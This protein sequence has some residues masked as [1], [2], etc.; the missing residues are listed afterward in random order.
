MRHLYRVIVTF[1][2]FY[3]LAE[4]LLHV[5]I[6]LRLVIAFSGRAL[7]E[8]HIARVS[9]NDLPIDHLYLLVVL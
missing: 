4:E 2:K 3:D 7:A 9:S 6:N 1:T 8:N 5:A